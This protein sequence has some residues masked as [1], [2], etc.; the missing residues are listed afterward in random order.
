[1][2]LVSTLTLATLVLAAAASAA[3]HY[4]LNLDTPQIAGDKELKPGE[5]KVEM[6]GDKAVFKSGKTVVE[7]PAALQKADKKYA[8]TTYQSID[9]KIQEIDLGG[10]ASKIVFVAP[11]GSAAASK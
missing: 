1:M 4:T 2:K 10:T 11:S 7:V 3:T 8:L 5:Y 6:V 9:K